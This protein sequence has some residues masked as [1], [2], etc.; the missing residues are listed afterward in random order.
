M[1]IV[2]QTPDWV[3]GTRPNKEQFKYPI[4]KV[5]KKSLKGNPRGGQGEGSKLTRTREKRNLKTSL[6]K[7]PRAFGL[8][9]RGRKNQTS[10]WKRMGFDGGNVHEG[11][12]GTWVHLTK[13]P[14]P[15]GGKILGV[16]RLGKM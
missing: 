11:G 16:A 6:P 4:E 2:L 1:K 13:T 14:K 12:V 5:W 9:I 10:Q 15:K 8:L 3:V 7:T